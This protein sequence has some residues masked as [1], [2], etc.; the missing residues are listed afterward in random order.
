MNICTLALLP[1]FKDGVKVDEKII[2]FVETVQFIFVSFTF[3][4]YLIILFF[5]VDSQKQKSD[6]LRSPFFKLCISTAIVDIWTLLTNYFGAMFPKWGWGVSIYMSLDVIYTNLYLYFAWSTG[7]CQAM[8]VSVLAA[9]R[10]SAM[11]F[12][13]IYK[14]LWSGYKL[15]IAISIQFFFGLTIGMATYFNPTVLYRT[16]KNGVVSK[17]TNDTLTNAFFALGGV[18]L[19][20]CVLFL[21]SSYCYLFYRLRQQNQKRFKNSVNRI[22][23]RKHPP[24]KNHSEFRLFIM[25]S[26]IVAIQITVFMLFVV[27]AT[28]IIPLGAETFYLI[29]NALS[30]VYA[31]IN[32][33]LLWIFSKDLRKY[34]IDRTWLSRKKRLRLTTSV[35]SLS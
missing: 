7:I 23:I 10:V 25:S 15:T 21:I 33:Y 4:F 26:I 13:D 18:F 6:K 1:P 3:P 27:R 28:N 31:G 24:K 11:L 8:S 14:E 30:D 19:L 20:F 34:I 35:I 16:E 17:F 22:G 29:Y 5:L 32:P 12:P 2:N 9:N